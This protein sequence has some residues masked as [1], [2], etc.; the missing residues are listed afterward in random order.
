MNEEPLTTDRQNPDKPKENGVWWRPAVQIFSEISTWIAVPIVLALVA[1]RYLD[2][3]YGTKPMMLLLLA[4][5]GFLIS[6]YGIIRTVKIYTKKLKD[7]SD[8]K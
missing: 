1:G 3:R 5:L 7:D 6:S 4:G 2:T 8:K